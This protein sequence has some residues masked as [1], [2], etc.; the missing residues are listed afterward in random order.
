[1]SQKKHQ[2]N[3]TILVFYNLA[4]FAMFLYFILTM[5]INKVE[6]LFTGFILLISNI[7]IPHIMFLREMSWGKYATPYKEG[8][9]TF[10][11]LKV[12]G[13]SGT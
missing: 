4:V 3:L 6:I 13:M 7:F 12:S 1:M 8:Y 9:S 10:I 5:D 2:N 11:A